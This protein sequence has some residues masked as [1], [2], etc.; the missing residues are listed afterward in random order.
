MHSLQN[1]GGWVSKIPEDSIRD[2]RVKR[3]Q[4]I[5]ISGATRH[6][7]H[8]APLEP[9]TL[10]SRLILGNETIH[11]A[12]EGYLV[13]DK[14]LNVVEAVQKGTAIIVLDRYFK[15]QQGTTAFIIKGEDQNKLFMGLM[16]PLATQETKAHFGANYLDVL[17]WWQQSRQ[18]VNNTIFVRE[19]LS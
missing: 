1:P 15:K 7:T 19:Q 12:T 2:T 4:H 13:S 10:S 5:R 9:S 6:N 16:W 14:G 11:G 18:Y 17:W 3:G 8:D